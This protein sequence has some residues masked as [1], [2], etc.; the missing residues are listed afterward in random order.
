MS[1][2]SVDNS[3]L[4][5]AYTRY[6]EAK[7]LSDRQSLHDSVDQPFES[8]Y[9]AKQILQDL[10]DTTVSTEL[11]ATDD[12]VD[13]G[14]DDQ[15]NSGQLLELLL[16]YELGAIDLD[17]E[18][19][20]NAT[21]HFQL[22][23]KLL[24]DITGGDSGGA[25]DTDANDN[26]KNRLRLS[27]TLMSVVVNNQLGFIWCSRSDYT[28]AI[29]YLQ[30]AKQ[31][32]DWWSKTSDD[33][34]R[35]GLLLDFAD[36]FTSKPLHESNVS[37]RLAAANETNNSNKGLKNLESGHTLTLYLMAQT[38]EKLG[39]NSQSAVYCHSTLKRQYRSLQES[40]ESSSSSPQ[41]D[42][43]L[44]YD[45][46]DWALNAATLSQYFASNDD[47]NASRHHICCALKV[48]NSLALLSPADIESDK[49]RKAMAD[50]NR[51]VVKYSI[52]LL[53][54]SGTAIRDN[55]VVT[56]ITEQTDEQ[57]ST[58]DQKFRPYLL[59]DREVEELEKTIKTYPIRTLS[60][61]QQVFKYANQCLTEAMEFYKLDERASDYISCIQ[62]RS[63]LYQYLI[64]FDS[65]YD[66]QCRMHKRRVD[67]LEELIKQINPKIFVGQYRQLLFELAEIH[68]QMAEL[69]T[70][71]MNDK[72]D[73][74]SAAIDDRQM[75][76]AIKKIN[77]LFAKSIHN[78][79][80]F[81]KTFVDEKSANKLPDSLP[82]DY[83]RPVLL[84]VFSIGRLYSKLVT[85]DPR[86]QLRNWSKC[87]D[88]Y[89]QCKDYLDRNPEHRSEHFADEW[90][91]LEEMLS[92]IPGKMQLILNSTMY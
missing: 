88:N 60:A 56:T 68:T 1:S 41:I 17:T 3:W 7:D 58:G 37:R 23:R 35:L 64:P 63:K 44:M 53:E 91:L 15:L 13:D 2:S 75:L 12:K 69:K 81:I 21:K 4:S 18:E 80:T 67:A 33:H 34:L 78:F 89:Q 55:L 73:D 9:K 48:I 25:A 92:L 65:D 84:A 76:V 52:M 86:E 8:K 79:D 61:A 90:P 20:S 87:E 31:A 6:L 82:A 54:S 77:L 42:E 14:N 43:P 22:S 85:R 49:Y 27:L 24:M 66:R 36:L 72:S 28:E 38:Y 74:D 26:Q 40:S 16:H 70:C 51:I 11:V 47:F 39:D 50:I 32:Y 71:I 29:G 57:Q 10:L 46:I 83:I 19:P 62:D 30:E 45:R 59:N 5:S